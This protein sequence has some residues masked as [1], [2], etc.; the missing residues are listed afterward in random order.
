MTGESE[1]GTRVG[2]KEGSWGFE[3]TQTEEE[4]DGRRPGLGGVRTARRERLGSGERSRRSRG[5]KGQDPPDGSGEEEPVAK[6]ESRSLSPRT[7]WSRRSCRR[8]GPETSGTTLLQPVD[9]GARGRAGAELSRALLGPAAEPGWRAGLL[10]TDPQPPPPPPPPP[11]LG[12][13]QHRARPAA[14]TGR[15]PCWRCARG[16]QGWSRSLLSSPL[17]CGW[18]SRNADAPG[19]PHTRRLSAAAAA[20]ARPTE[21]ASL[22]RGAPPASHFYSTKSF[23]QT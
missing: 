6:E 16:S 19:A 5:R 17:G 22:P 21:C 11:P 10:H 20:A 18:R 23:I 15:G 2:L 9:R 7:W 8:L 4:R 3:T 1:H 12:V 14:A 13:A